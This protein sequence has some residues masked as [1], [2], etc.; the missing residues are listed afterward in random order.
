MRIVCS[1]AN[2]GVVGGPIAYLIMDAF[3]VQ[4]DI[5]RANRAVTSYEHSVLH[6]ANRLRGT[7]TGRVVLRNVQRLA[8][9][10]MTIL[11]WFTSQL[12]EDDR[13]RKLRKGDWEPINATATR[14][15]P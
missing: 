13:R 8:P 4:F 6:E 10:Q 5:D 2:V 9:R 1:Y 12:Q 7:M 3:G 15:R 11:P 14:V